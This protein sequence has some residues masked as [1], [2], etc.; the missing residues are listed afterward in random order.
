LVRQAFFSLFFVYSKV[1]YLSES[2]S[3]LHSPTWEKVFATL[4]SSPLSVNTEEL[5]KNDMLLA[6]HLYAFNRLRITEDVNEKLSVLQT[7]QTYMAAY[8]PK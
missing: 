2:N 1:P 3:A 6:L 5:V 4:V 8:K 7:I